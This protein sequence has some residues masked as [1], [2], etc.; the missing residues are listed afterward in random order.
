MFLFALDQTILPG[1][2]DQA[3]SFVPVQ[4]DVK[5]DGKEKMPAMI[6]DLLAVG[7]Q[8]GFGIVL[9]IGQEAICMQGPQIEGHKDQP[10]VEGDR[11]LEFGISLPHDGERLFM[12]LLAKEDTTEGIHIVNVIGV[13][14]PDGQVSVPDRLIV[15]ATEVV[16]EQPVAVVVDQE[17]AGVIDALAQELIVTIKLFAEG[18]ELL[19]VE[20]EEGQPDQSHVSVGTV[21]LI[22]RKDVRE[23]SLP[24]DGFSRAARILFDDILGGIVDLVAD[25][26]RVIIMGPIGAQKIIHLRML[27]VPHA[28]QQKM[29]VLPGQ[30][31]DLG[32]VVAP[33]IR[34]LQDPGQE[35]FL[36]RLDAVGCDLFFQV[37]Q[38]T[39]LVI[40]IDGGQ[41]LTDPGD[42]VG[43][44]PLVNFLIKRK[45]IP[46]EPT[47]MIEPF[48]D[49]DLLRVGELMYR[50]QPSR[51][52]RKEA[53]G[54]FL[55]FPELLFHLRKLQ[56]IRWRGECRLQRQS[57]IHTQDCTIDKAGF[58]GGEEEIGIGQL[59]H[60][61]QAL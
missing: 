32:E 8:E 56:N 46:N 22:I 2:P 53:F 39:K 13:L 33:V 1:E 60:S 17:P 41:S 36:I 11:G 40:D 37:D 43:V 54:E 10:V 34:I 24:L 12:L 58:R 3:S 16:Q 9:R 19:V 52:M 44:F 51:F 57:T 47:V 20:I 5:E 48:E 35:S 27:S 6:E 29:A 45:G 30:G 21:D 38:D 26:P 42:D 14:F 25:V 18:F 55:K 59:F 61:A 23:P 49:G 28:D 4:E 15:F 31:I 50:D 7:A